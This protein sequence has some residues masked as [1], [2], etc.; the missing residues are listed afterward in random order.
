MQAANDNHR[1]L[2]NSVDY[3]LGAE[4]LM[5]VRSKRPLRR[6]FLLFDEIEAEA[7]LETLERERQIRADIETFQQELRDKQTAISARNASLFEKRVQDEVE[8]VNEKIL[9]AN[10][11]LREIRR[12][13]R[14]TLEAQETFVRFAVIGLMPL[15]V[16]ALGIWR[17][18][19]RSRARRAS[20]GRVA[21][22][23]EAKSAKASPA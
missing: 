4:E 20:S 3:L 23:P 21:E 10:Q 7:E 11:E 13:R 8:A 1:V 17:A 2:L 14:A 19:E 16:L 22:Q 5:A 18:V 12:D 9:A 15:L 6:P